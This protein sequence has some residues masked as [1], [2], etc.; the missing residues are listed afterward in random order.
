MVF[1]PRGTAAVISCERT[2]LRILNPINLFE[3]AQPTFDQQWPLAVSP[4]GRMMATGASLGRIFLWDLQEVRTQIARFGLD[5][6][7]EETGGF[8]LPV[9]DVPAPVLVLPST[10]QP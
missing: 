7:K 1:S 10:G 2:R 8:P 5:W 4:R 3:M 9:I 6:T